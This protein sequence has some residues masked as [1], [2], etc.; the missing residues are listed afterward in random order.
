MSSSAAGGGLPEHLSTQRAEPLELTSPLVAS[1]LLL[2]LLLLLLPAPQ[3]A[4]Q[5]LRESAKTLRIGMIAGD[6]IGRNVL[7]VRPS[8]SS[9][10]GGGSTTG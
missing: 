8:S 3:M 4:M 5:A 1:A 10:L 7:P 9:S 2:L 6:G